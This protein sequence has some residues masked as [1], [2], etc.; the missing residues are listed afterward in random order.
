MLHSETYLNKKQNKYSIIQY[1][2]KETK[3]KAY[4]GSTV[5]ISFNSWSAAR[6][7]KGKKSTMNTQR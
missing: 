1:L 5:L 4:L 7:L 3:E 6:D 2:T